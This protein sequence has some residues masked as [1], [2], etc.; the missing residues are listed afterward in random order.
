M[1]VRCVELSQF[2]TELVVAFMNQ[3]KDAPISTSLCRTVFRRL[4]GKPPFAQSRV[5]VYPQSAAVAQ[6]AIM[7]K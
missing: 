3:P 4:E 6:P 2:E 7:S 1:K 5:R